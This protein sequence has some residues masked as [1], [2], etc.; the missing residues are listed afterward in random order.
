MV[1]GYLHGL[2]PMDLHAWFE[3]YLDGRWYAFDATQ[4]A[5]PR[6]PHRR[7]LWPR[8]RRRRLPHQLWPAADP[9]HAGLGRPEARG[10]WVAAST[11]HAGHVVTA[12]TVALMASVH[13]PANAPAPDAAAPDATTRDLI[14]TNLQQHGF[15]PPPHAGEGWGGGKA[16]RIR[17]VGTFSRTREKGD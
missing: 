14:S 4:D 5:P 17:P 3:A 11:I 9:G 16:A 13:R 6:R 15:T 1:V 12:P 10:R 2:A 7:R 8:R